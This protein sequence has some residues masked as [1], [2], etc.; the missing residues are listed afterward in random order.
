MTPATYKYHAFISYSHTDR[1]WANWL[2]RALETYRVPKRLVAA[3]A[4]AR[5]SP[6]FRDREELPSANNLGQKIEEALLASRCFIVICSPRAAQSALGQRGD[7]S[8]QGDGT[9]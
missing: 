2:H 9:R 1:V 3:G 4:P 7:R 8:L 6:I 5:L